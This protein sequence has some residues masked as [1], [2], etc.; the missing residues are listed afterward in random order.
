M[1]A[2]AMSDEGQP[3]RPISAQE[4]GAGQ[5]AGW[6]SPEGRFY[7]CEV[8]GHIQLAARLRAAGAGP[9]DPWIMERSR[10]LLV[11]GHGE[12]LA[13]PGRVTQAQLNALMGILL[14]APNGSGYRAQLH[15][16]LRV[17]SE[18]EEVLAARRS[19][20]AIGALLDDQRDWT[21]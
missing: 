16:A 14:A 2:T 11:K 7:A 9:A 1:R 17:L 18:M 15:Q 8:N 10:W 12:V 4:A 5:R 6:M 20:R 3:P 21:R 13:L 19:A